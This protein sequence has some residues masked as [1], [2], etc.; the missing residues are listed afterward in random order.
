MHISLPPN[1]DSPVRSPV[2]GRGGGR[3]LQLPDVGVPGLPLRLR[4]ADAGVRRRQAVDPG[5]LPERGDG[6]LPDGGGQGGRR[7][8]GKEEGAGD[9]G[10]EGNLI[11]C[12][13]STC[14]RRT[15]Q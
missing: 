1:N 2:Q 10:G 9:A 11:C 12:R 6:R 4:P 5:G 7:R 13:Y 15:V 8:Y 3:L 14:R